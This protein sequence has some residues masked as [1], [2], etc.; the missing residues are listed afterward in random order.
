L[1]QVIALASEEGE[2]L[3]ALVELFERHHV[4][5]AHGLDARLHV[6]VVGFCHRQFFAG[7]ERC[8]G[9]NQI[10]GLCVHF[11]HAR[12]A[13]VLAVGIVARA[14]D[15]RVAALIAQLVQRLASHAQLVFHL[16]Y[17]GPVGLP[18]CFQ[19]ALAG[20]EA[21]FFR[22]QAFELLSELFALRG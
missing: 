2:A 6:A 18:L 7:N 20:F 1:Q 16:G 11:G 8:F 21:C 15:F 5:R 13:Q 10:F 9:G 17:A 12:F 19:R 3:L 22:A 14:I 4:H